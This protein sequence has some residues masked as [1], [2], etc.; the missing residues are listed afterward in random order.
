MNFSIYS[1]CYICQYQYLQDT[2]L[3]SL[4]SIAIILYLQVKAS[5][6]ITTYRKLDLLRGRSKW[7]ERSFDFNLSFLAN[8]GVAF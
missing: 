3:L 6:A 7:Y 4:E 8:H 2:L 1:R 5:I